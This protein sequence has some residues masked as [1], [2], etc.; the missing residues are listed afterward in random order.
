MIRRDFSDVRGNEDAVL[1]VARAVIRRQGAILLGPPGTGKTM[2]AVRTPALLGP[3][4]DHQRAWLTAEYEGVRVCPDGGITD[5]PFRAPHH[6]IS[7]AALTAG[8]MPWGACDRP[9]EPACRCK[10]TVPDR[11]CLFHTLPRGR[12]PQAGEVRLARFGILYLDEVGEF[13]RS[14]IEQLRVA[15]D[16]MGDSAPVVLAGSVRCPCGW[17]ESSV[18]E[19]TCTERM[20]ARFWA[21][22]EWAVIKL[23]LDYVASVEPVTLDQMRVDGPG[24]HTTAALREQFTELSA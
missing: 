21:R 8:R 20:V 6:T 11:P 1:T 23:G 5:R 12:V 15:L 14:A 3:L 17:R 18:R 9:I 10:Q 19:C 7:I 2:I 22:V 16:E 24:S 4:T 13:H